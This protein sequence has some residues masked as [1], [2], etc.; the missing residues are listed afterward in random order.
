MNNDDIIKEAKGLLTNYKKI[1]FVQHEYNVYIY[2]KYDLN[3]CDKYLDNLSKLLRKSVSCLIDNVNKY[4]LKLP[5]E[6]YSCT[7][8]H[9]DCINTDTA[10]RVSKILKSYLNIIFGEIKW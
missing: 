7:V 3:D 8:L 4:D 9:L 2:L 5:D 10:T 6:K 1:D